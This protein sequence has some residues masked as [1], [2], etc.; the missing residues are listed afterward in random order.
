MV[1]AKINRRKIP[2]SMV[3]D[4]HLL[5]TYSVIGNGYCSVETILIVKVPMKGTEFQ[6]EAS[7]KE[8]HQRR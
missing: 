7:L 5:W 3:I 8:S 1:I 2:F 4:R 6:G